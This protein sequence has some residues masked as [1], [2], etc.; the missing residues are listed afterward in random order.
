MLMVAMEA[1][2]RGLPW[3]YALHNGQQGVYYRTAGP[4]QGT[5]GVRGIVRG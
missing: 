3:R 5:G 1:C 2:A 4:P